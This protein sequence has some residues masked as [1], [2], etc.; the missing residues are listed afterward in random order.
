MGKILIIGI[1]NGA[2][3]AV[4]HMKDVGIPEANYITFGTGTLG[5]DNEESEIPHYDLIRMNGY[6]GISLGWGPE[7]FEYLAENVKDDIR[8]ILEYHINGVN[9][10]DNEKH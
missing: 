5:R 2:R 9:N 1:G 7:T 10:E 4:K 8:E 6:N 3:E